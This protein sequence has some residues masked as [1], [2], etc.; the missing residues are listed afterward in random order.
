LSQKL[1]WKYQEFGHSTVQKHWNINWDTIKQGLGSIKRGINTLSQKRMTL[2][3]PSSTGQTAL[4]HF[5]VFFSPKSLACLTMLIFKGVVCVC[6]WRKK[7]LLGDIEREK[8]RGGGELKENQVKR[9]KKKLSRTSLKPCS[10][11]MD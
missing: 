2:P 7:P 1:A 11:V 6:V 9:R 5:L 8:T 3:L 4:N 10:N